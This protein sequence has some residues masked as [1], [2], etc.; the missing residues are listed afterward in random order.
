MTTLKTYIVE[1][2]KVIRDNLVS[3]LEELVPVKVVGT[4]VDE[5]TA[6]RT[7]VDPALRPKQAPT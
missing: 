1:D 7:G 2:N 4:A 3:A 5:F 6:E